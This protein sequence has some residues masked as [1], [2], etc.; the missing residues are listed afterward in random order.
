MPQLERDLATTRE[1][2]ALGD[3]RAEDGLSF[4]LPRRSRLDASWPSQAPSRI[5]R[6][7]RGKIGAHGDGV[8]KFRQA[9]V[10]GDSPEA[11]HNREHRHGREPLDRKSTRLNS[12][13]AK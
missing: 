9:W 3:A 8:F 10:A 2:Q 5:Q 11:R 1:F 6:F 4:A 13:H 12:S 7:E